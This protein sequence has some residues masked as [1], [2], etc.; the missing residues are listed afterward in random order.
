MEPRSKRAGSSPQAWHPATGSLWLLTAAFFLLG[1]LV[2]LRHEMWQDEWQAW[3]LARESSSLADLFQNIRYEGH[4]CLW[5]L[6]LFVISRFTTDPLG[7]QLLHL[8]IATGTV[9]IFLKYSPFTRLQKILFIFGYFP[10]YE[11]CAISRNYGLGVLS[12]FSFCAVFA[13]GEPRRSA[14]PVFTA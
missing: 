3:L 2:L 6:A 4:P 11:Y 8:M 13:S 5:Y 12:L 10:F 9:Y 14:R 7:M 1:L